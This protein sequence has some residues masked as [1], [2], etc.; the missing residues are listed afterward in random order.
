MR[1]V[2]TGVTISGADI[3]DAFDSDHSFVTIQQVIDALPLKLTP[4][5]RAVL[6]TE[7]VAVLTAR[8]NNK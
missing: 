7:A 4:E 8:R 5:Q 2:L 3:V 1:V 6:R